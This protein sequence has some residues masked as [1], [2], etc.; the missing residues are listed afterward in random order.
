M[1][2]FTPLANDLFRLAN[3]SGGVVISVL[4]RGENITPCVAIGGGPIDEQVMALGCVQ[5][6]LTKLVVTLAEANGLDEKE[7]AT[8]VREIAKDVCD[9]EFSAKI[10]RS[11]PRT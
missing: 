6:L 5:G 2:E 8:A 11:T 3:E 9:G 10:V 4:G 7:I 1:G